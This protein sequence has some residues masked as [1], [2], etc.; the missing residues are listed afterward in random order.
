MHP[1]EANQLTYP[2][3]ISND[4]SPGCEPISVHSAKSADE[5]EKKKEQTICDSAPG[6]VKMKR[7]R[8][9]LNL[10]KH[11]PDK[12]SLLEQK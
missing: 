1:S 2:H 4:V 11:V 3:V 8:I 7:P 6:R 5:N 10:R 12:S 9:A